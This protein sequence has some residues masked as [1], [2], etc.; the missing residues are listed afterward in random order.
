VSAKEPVKKSPA[1]TVTK[2]KATPKARV[3]EA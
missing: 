2:A 3:K 1:K